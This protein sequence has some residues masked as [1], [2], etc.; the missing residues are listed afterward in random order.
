MEKF[1]YYDAITGMSEIIR[2]SFVNNAFDGA[3]TMLGV[4]LGGFITDIADPTHV[5]KLGLATAIAV[6]VSGL[7][8][9]L[10]AE[11]AERKRQI[12]DMEEA[13]HRSLD[14]TEVK[15]AH[16]SASILTALVDGLSPLLASILILSPFFFVTPAGIN[17]AYATSIVISMSV[18]FSIGMFLGKIA[19]ESMLITGTKLVM[20]GLVCMFLILLLEGIG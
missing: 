19:E 1:E 3:L 9:A 11:T 20:A 2:R 16:D 6:G 17:I 13:L 12:K 14:N 18:F 10:F 8:G 4:L 5:I 7:T 15:D